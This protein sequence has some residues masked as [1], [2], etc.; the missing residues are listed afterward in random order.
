MRV[1][2]RFQAELIAGGRSFSESAS[3]PKTSQP[4]FMTLFTNLPFPLLGQLRWFCLASVKSSSSSSWPRCS[5]SRGPN[6]G[7]H[8]S[9]LRASRNKDQKGQQTIT[10][11]HD[12]MVRGHLKIA[13]HRR[14]LTKASL[15]PPAMHGCNMCMS[16]SLWCRRRILLVISDQGVQD[17]S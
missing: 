9:E 17:A 7:Q 13:S 16:A 6:R 14:H 15:T 1:S 4:I 2:L 3:V 11:R 8:Q 5:L 12:D 10:K